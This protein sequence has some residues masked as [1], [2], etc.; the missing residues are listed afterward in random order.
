MDVAFIF[1]GMGRSGT[2]WLR[3]LLDG[4]PDVKVFHEPC[5]EYDE[6]NYW[7]VAAG[8]MSEEEFVERRI[9][10]M[11]GVGEQIPA[12]MR[13]AEVN[14]YLRYVAAPL[15]HKFRCSVQGI[16]RDGRWT[17]RSLDVMGLFRRPGRPPI[18]SPGAY[19]TPF[20][21]CVWYWA[22]TYEE[23]DIVGVPI[24]TLEG[25]NDEYRCV[26]SLCEGS[27]GIEPPSRG[28]WSKLRHRRV[29]QLPGGW[30]SDPPE[31]TE[32]Q[33]AAFWRIGGHVQARYYTESGRLARGGC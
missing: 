6:A 26:A 11:A 9:A 20:E 8:Q 27:L 22:S 14:S 17:V 1:T 19:E 2:K 21:K 3:H 33:E 28:H 31:F 12:G 4:S 30:T 5:R 32:E 15:R 23:L 24:W 29:N 10:Y 7:K 18:P 25:L 13:Y 16:V